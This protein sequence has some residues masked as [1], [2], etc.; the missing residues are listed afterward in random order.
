MFELIED[1]IAGWEA[2]TITGDKTLT[3]T[4]Y[5]TDQAR[6]AMLEFDGSPSAAFEITIPAA[7]KWYFVK[8]SSGQRATI[9]AGGVGAVAYNGEVVAILCDGTDCYRTESNTFG[10]DVSMGSNN[11]A[12]LADP[13]ADQHA[14]TKKYVDDENTSQSAAITASQAAAAASAATATAAQAAAEAA[15][16]SAEAALDSFDDRYLGSKASAPTVDNDGD[17]LVEGSVYWNSA[18]NALN[19]Y[20]GSSWVP[21]GSG[22]MSIQDASSVAITGGSINGATVGATTPASGAFTTL[23]AS[24]PF[25]AANGSASNPSLSFTSDTNLGIY[26]AAIDALGFAAGGSNIGVWTTTGL[27]IGTTSPD[28]ALH[29]VGQAVFGANTSV[30]GS[31]AAVFTATSSFAAGVEIRNHDAAGWARLDVKHDSASDGFLMYQ[32]A[33]GSLSFRNNSNASTAMK[34][35]VGATAYMTLLSG[36]NVGIGTTSPS[37][38]LTAFK[39]G[40]GNVAHISNGLT[41][42][43]PSNTHGEF[44]VESTDA[45]MGIELLGSTSA[46]Q[47]IS[48]SDNSSAVGR[49]V[50]QHSSNFMSLWTNNLERLRIDSSGDVGIGTTNPLS[51]LHIF[52]AATDKLIQKWQADLGI[53][54]RSLNLTSPATD[55]ATD[56]FVF[57]TGNSLA[58]DVDASRVIEA[59]AS[60][61]T[62]L[63]QAAG[64]VGIRT[65]SPDYELDVAGDVQLN[66][67]LMM[68]S[69]ATLSISSGAIT[70]THSFHEV[71]TEGLAATDDLDT[72]NGGVDGAILVIRADNDAED[73]ITLTTA[74]NIVG[75]LAMPTIRSNDTATL[76]YSSAIS[77]WILLS[78]T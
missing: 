39:S 32:D 47:M 55:S 18:S 26:R 67:R 70:V 30:V 10:Q 63:C 54:D 15:Q 7:P 43:T 50:Y 2:H 74:G 69:G 71:S 41:G 36:G 6:M 38:P 33:T 34:W 52:V 5:A 57:Q 4:N 21:F 27:G 61:N 9:T 1:A 23:S 28:R 75:P 3:S 77:K 62:L 64:R 19:I 42:Y 76:I 59:D 11:I 65:T 40:V 24:S 29:V 49:I 25:L 73:D 48:F 46:N 44:V 60:G 35:A 22:T 72:I 20:N 68:G 66:G 37:Y 56:P 17:P 13:T 78:S 16:T 45:N 53:N 58:I 8:N 12:D 14:A 31:T 51:P